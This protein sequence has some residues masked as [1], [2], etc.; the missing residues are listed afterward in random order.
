M[1]M[2][3]YNDFITKLFTNNSSVIEVDV[4]LMTFVTKIGRF[5]TIK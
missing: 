5:E 3:E 4:D 1:N 2:N